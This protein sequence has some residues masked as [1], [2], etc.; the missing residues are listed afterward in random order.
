MTFGT[1]LGDTTVVVGSIPRDDPAFGYDSM[2][3]LDPGPEPRFGFR[4]PLRLHW[5]KHP[6]PAAFEWDIV[7]HLDALLVRL[8]RIR[9]SE[10]ETLADFTA[11]MWEVFD[12]RELDRLIDVTP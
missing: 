4:A 8:N 3:F 5:L 6:Q 2:V 1:E 12:A 9:D 10:T 11:S 7:P